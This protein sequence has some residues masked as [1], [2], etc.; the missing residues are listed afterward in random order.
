VVFSHLRDKDAFGI[1]PKAFRIGDLLR[2]VGADNR[3]AERLMALLLVWPDADGGYTPMMKRG[4]KE[5]ARQQ[6]AVQRYGMEPVQVLQ[7]YA[8]DEFDDYARC[9]R[10]ALIWE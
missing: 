2:R 5:A 7:R 4:R 8:R 10:A 1:I 3:S 6:Q 9:K